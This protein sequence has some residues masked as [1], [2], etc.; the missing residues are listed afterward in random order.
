MI[1]N[2]KHYARAIGLLV[3]LVIAW[4][5]WSG[6]YKPLLLSLGAFSCLLCVYLAHRVGFF[7][8]RS[9]LH[10]IARLPGY[11]L[12][13]FVEIVKSSIDVAKIVLNPKLPISPTVVELKA[14]PKGPIGQA[15]LGNSI[16]LSPGT[17]T[18]DVHE[19]IL[20]VHC[21]T[22][23]SAND[24]LTGESNRRAASLTVN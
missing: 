12:W 19:G 4:L 15:I 22:Q 23:A 16:T 14:K 17:V 13:L 10:L 6:L 21:L 7:K 18:L 9:G 20:Q 11:W 2:S 5:V 3:L 1:E 8:E 24:L